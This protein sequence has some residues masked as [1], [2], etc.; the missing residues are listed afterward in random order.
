MVLHYLT[1]DLV[2]QEKEGEVCG[3]AIVF[4]VWPLPSHRLPTVGCHNAKI[5]HP[6][7]LSFTATEIVKVGLVEASGTA[8]VAALPQV[9]GQ[10]LPFI[11]EMD[12][13][14]LAQV[15]VARKNPRLEMW[16]ENGRRFAGMAGVGHSVVDGMEAVLL[17]TESL[18]FQ[19]ALLLLE[20]ANHRLNL[21]AA[22]IGTLSTVGEMGDLHRR[23]ENLILVEEVAVM[24]A[25][26]LLEI[27][28]VTRVG[29]RLA[30]IGIIDLGA[31]ILLVEDVI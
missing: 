16:V 8:A 27:I 18:H 10:I 19:A 26:E 24:E 11:I 17:P 29:N 6:P 21:I 14:E 9:L 3:I 25:L 12:L 1:A 13:L 7:P 22:S 28:I 4:Q 20:E 30:A 23:R 31:I 15:E 2:Q 5:L